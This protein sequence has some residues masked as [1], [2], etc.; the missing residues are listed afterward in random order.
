[1]IDTHCTITQISQWIQEY[2]QY[3][4]CRQIIVTGFH[5][6]W[7]AHKHP[8]FKAILN[9]ADL[10]VPDGIAPVWVARC[11]G[12]LNVQRTPGTELMKAFFELADHKGYKSFFYV[13]T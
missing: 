8:D 9:S 13:Y 12:F 11:K 5:G 7:E 3:C 6:I 4:K 2:N 10:W 1:M